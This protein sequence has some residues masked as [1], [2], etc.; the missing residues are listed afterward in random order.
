[1]KQQKISELEEKV[2]TI[3]KQSVFVLHYYAGSVHL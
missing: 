2:T 3:E 1:M